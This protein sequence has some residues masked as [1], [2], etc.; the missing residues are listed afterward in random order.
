[1]AKCD[2]GYLCEVCGEEVAGITD[3]DLYLRFVLGEVSAAEL[4]G[5]PERHLRCNPTVSQFI[6]DERFERPRVEGP[7]ARE[8]LDRKFAAAEAERVT[9]AYRRLRTVVRL[10]LP[11]E[12]YP[13]G[14]GASHGG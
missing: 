13:V 9:A 4:P 2:E 7:F 1:M 14:G 11:I 5:S 8:E 3:S 12:E 10:R 6:D